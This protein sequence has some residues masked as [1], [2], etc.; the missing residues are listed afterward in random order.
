MSN[1]LLSNLEGRLKD[2]R[3]HL[4]KEVNMRLNKFNR[5]RESWVTDTAEIASNIMED[6]TVMSIAQG[7]AREISLIDNTL[8]KIKKGK[9]GVCDCCGSHINKQRLIAIPFVSL[10]IKCKEDEERDNGIMINR[11]EFS[12]SE[13]FETLEE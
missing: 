2:R 3:R 8:E 7:E 12:E 4:L 9:Y 11:T 10:C 1:K 6:N 13:E 5:S